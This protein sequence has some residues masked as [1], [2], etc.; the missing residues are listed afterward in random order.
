MDIFKREQE[1]AKSLC[2][3]RDEIIHQCGIKEDPKLFML[4]LQSDWVHG[5][6]MWSMTASSDSRWDSHWIHVETLEVL[7]KKI[8]EIE[9]QLDNM[10]DPLDREIAECENKLASLKQQ[11]EQRT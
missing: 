11:K 10:P 6:S 1:L 3:I 5:G 2:A 4:Y 9:H 7:I 8:E